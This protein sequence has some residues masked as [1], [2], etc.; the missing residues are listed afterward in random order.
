MMT[1]VCFDTH[2]KENTRP[3][4]EVTWWL[5]TFMPPGMFVLIVSFR[6]ICTSLKILKKMKNYQKHLGTF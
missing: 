3:G 1:E 5:V 6:W 4:M 2:G